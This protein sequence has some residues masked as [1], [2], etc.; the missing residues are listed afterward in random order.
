MSE[1]KNEKREKE[2]D[3]RKKSEEVVFEPKTK[4]QLVRENRRESST[5]LVKEAPYLLV[6]SKKEKIVSPLV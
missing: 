2:K 1:E 6:P 4:S 5:M 3:E